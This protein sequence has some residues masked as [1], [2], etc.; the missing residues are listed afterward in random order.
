MHCGISYAESESRL[1]LF[2]ASLPAA[3]AET[4]FFFFL[5]VNLIQLDTL[6]PPSAGAGDLPVT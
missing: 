5:R 2:A 4:L 1:E 3:S 6:V